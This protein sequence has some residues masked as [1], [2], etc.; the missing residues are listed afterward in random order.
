MALDHPN[1]REL[2]FFPDNPLS[3]SEPYANQ[4]KESTA[5]QVPQ[6]FRPQPSLKIF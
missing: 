3:K 1:F 2:G 4:G 6:W 5:A